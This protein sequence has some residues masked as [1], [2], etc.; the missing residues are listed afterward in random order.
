MKTTTLSLLFLLVG[1]ATTVQA[2]TVPSP[3]RFVDPGQAAT[4]YAGYV[5]AQPGTLDL[6]PEPGPIFGARYQLRLSGPLVALGGVGLLTTTRAVLDTVPADTTLQV[7][8]DA[9]LDLLLIKA[10]LRFDITGS[11]TYRSFQPFLRANGGMAIG[12]GGG[13]EESDSLPSDVQF[14]FGTSFLFELGTGLEW[15]LRPATT[16]RVDATTTLWKV[17]TPRPFLFG[18]AG[19]RRPDA[20]WT[21]NFGLTFGLS[22]RF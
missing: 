14:D 11:R 13:S 16:F 5:W 3:Y 15:Y 7:V 17:R 9:G 6:G 1:V 22:I 12:V 2:Q 19:L 4:L 10:G 18:D 8:G 20:D 21:Q